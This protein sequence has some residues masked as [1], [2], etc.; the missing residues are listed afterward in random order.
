MPCSY[1]LPP[2]P[3]RE[4]E[5]REHESGSAAQS[6]GRHCLWG[7]NSERRWVESHCGR[8]QGGRGTSPSLPKS[9]AVTARVLSRVVNSEPGPCRLGTRC[10]QPRRGGTYRKAWIPLRV[11]SDGIL[12]M[13]LTLTEL[14]RSF[15]V[16]RSPCSNDSRV[17]IT[18]GWW[19]QLLLTAPGDPACWPALHNGE[20]SVPPGR[21]W[22]RRS[23][24]CYCR[25]CCCCSAVHGKAM[26]VTLGTVCL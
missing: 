15:R 2:S 22:V 7:E 4:E 25:C 8:A 21:A 24:Y 17:E 5:G 19:L 1:G 16:T 18:L 14:R 12:E 3:I 26:C 10:N 20:T 13:P 6:S 11:G 23:V 9:T